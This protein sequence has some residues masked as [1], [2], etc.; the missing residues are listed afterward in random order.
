MSNMERL[1]HQRRD[2]YYNPR[3]HRV[4][5]PSIQTYQRLQPGK[6]LRL[7]NSGELFYT[8]VEQLNGKKKKIKHCTTCSLHTLNKEQVS[9]KSGF[10]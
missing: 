6:R 3:H 2:P 9:T 8:T 7:K 4:H 5:G 10:R 1:M